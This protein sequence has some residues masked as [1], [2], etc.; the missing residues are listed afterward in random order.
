MGWRDHAIDDALLYYGNAPARLIYSIRH[1]L[2]CISTLRLWVSLP[3]ALRFFQREAEDFESLLV[4]DGDFYDGRTGVLDDFGWYAVRWKGEPIEIVVPPPPGSE[5]SGHRQ[6]VCSAWSA[7]LLADFAAS[8]QDH[9]SRLEGRCL[10]YSEGAWRSAP[11]LLAEVREISWYD[12]VLPPDVRVGIRESVEGFFRHREAYASWGFAWRRGILLVGPPGT[13]KTMICKAIAAALP[14]LP[15]LYVR[16]TR[17]YARE[18]IGEIFERARSLAPCVLAFEDL[19]GLVGEHNR[20]MFLNEL[21]GFASND[22]IL[23][24]ASSNHPG[25]I[26]EALLKRPSRFDRVFHIGVPAYEEREEYCRGLLY[27]DATLAEKL[28]S[29]LDADALARRIASETEGFTPAYLKEVFVSAIVRR[30]GS[31]AT[32][33]DEEFAEAALESVAELRAHLDRVE[34]PQDLAEIR[35]VKSK[36]G[37]AK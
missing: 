1:H 13:G 32:E 17:G 8:L 14:E 10:R 16:E 23:V 4:S 11:D 33:L 36:F 19:D 27:R 37:F 25:K 15:F 26:D 9:A 6:I 5:P 22:G 3:S 34:M 20:T 31:G 35:P 12:V 2:P 21:D 18:P 28:T 7:G 29:D 24:V 30:A